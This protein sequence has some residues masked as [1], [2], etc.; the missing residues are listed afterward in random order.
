MRMTVKEIVEACGGRLLCGNENTVVTSVST[1]SRRISAGALFVP[2][3]GERTDAHM[4]IDAVF[5]AGAAATFTQNDTK[6]LDV[7]PWIAV[8]DTGA[9]LQ[10][11][12]AAYRSRFHIPVVGITGS[13]GKTTTKEMVALALSSSFRVMKT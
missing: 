12:A 2:L 6:K 9:A 5:A 13:V 10:Q 8:P 1:D 11:A 3:K 7:H 4:Y